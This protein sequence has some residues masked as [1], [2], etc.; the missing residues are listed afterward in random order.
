MWMEHRRA[1]TLTGYVFGIDV[2]EGGETCYADN[3]DAGKV[4]VVWFGGVDSGLW[5]YSPPSRKT[6]M[7]PI[8]LLL[9]T[10]NLHTIGIG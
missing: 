7:I 8:L 2:F 1:G 5:P 6:R 9:S 3:A 10:F 4:L